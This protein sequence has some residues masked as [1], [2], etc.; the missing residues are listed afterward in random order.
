[1]SPL[2]SCTVTSTGTVEPSSAV[3][4]QVN[5]V[6]ALNGGLCG[7]LTLTAYPD[8]CL[9]QLAI[10]DWTPAWLKVAF[11]VFTAVA[12]GAM[13]AITKTVTAAHAA[14]APQAAPVRR[15]IARTSR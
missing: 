5:L 10:S 3:A 11:D 9:I 1:M 8:F 6:P 12:R 15:L 4:M 2:L 13:T 7:Q 14:K